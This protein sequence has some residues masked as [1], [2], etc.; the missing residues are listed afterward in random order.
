MSR[1]LTVNV[2]SSSVKIAEFSKQETK[3][4]KIHSQTF[5][6][7]Q[8]E[9]EEQKRFVDEFSTQEPPLWI[10]HR[11]V[12]GGASLKEPL[13]INEQV[14]KWIEQFVPLAPLH[15]K[16]A[17]AWIRLCKKVFPFARQVALFDTSFYTQLPKV[18]RQYALPSSLSNELE[19]WRFGFHGLAH[20]NMYSQWLALHPEK[21]NESRI[22]S[23]QLG[24]GCSVT[25]ILHGQPID[26]SMGFT[27]AEGLMMATRSGDVDPGL[28]LYLL[29]I[30]KFSAENLERILTEESGL[31]GVSA[32]SADMRVLLASSEVAA[33]EAI[34]LYCYRI[35]KYIGAYWAV[36]GGVDAILWGGGVG[37]NAP[38][39]R[40]KILAPFASLGILIHSDLNQKENGKFASFHQKDSQVALWVVP[41]DEERAMLQE[42]M[43][44]I[45]SF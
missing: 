24:S 44:Q 13:E 38:F 27:P 16:G 25:A 12:H 37:E 18:A 19:I 9:E 4:E 35:R 21:K 41:V 14:E 15:Q 2:G 43:K 3:Y 5:A 39:I 11:V 45:Q 30:K 32:L 6:R 23:L 29:K 31:L 36:L 26:T 8:S 42:A 40:E 7:K 34:E 17:L 33:Q 20:Q 22:I 1:I 10:L 28:L